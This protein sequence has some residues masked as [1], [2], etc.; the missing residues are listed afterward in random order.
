[1]Q[2]QVS[3]DAAPS[4]TAGALVVPVFAGAALNGVAA[5]VDAVL[6]GELADA[7][8]SGEITG[9]L[10]EVVLI[11][12]KDAPFKRVLAVGLGERSKMTAGNVAKYAGTAVRYLGKRGV[13]EIAIAL[14]E[15][16]DAAA[17]AS[18]VAEG[19]IAGTLDATLYRTEADKPVVTERVTILSG[20]NADQSAV[21]TGAK[22][23]RILGEAVNAARTMALTPGNDMTPTHLAQRAKDLAADA[24]LGFDV[25]DEDQ[26][27]AKHMGS[28]LGVSRGSDE[29]ATLSVMTY[30]GDPSSNETLALVG[31][32]LTFDSGGIS[33]KPPENMHE[34]K[35]DMSGGAGVIAAM[36]AIGKLRPKLNVI[37]LVPSSENLPGP[38]AMKPGDILTAMNGKTIEVLNTDAEGRLILADALAYAVELGATKIIDAA[39]LTGACVVALGHAA[40]GAMSNDDGFV[41]R[42]LR[43]VADIGE[44]Y[45]RLPLYPEYDQQIKSE[46]ADLKNTGG[47]PGGA[48]TA[49]AFLKAFVSE[50]PWIHLDVAGTAYLDSESPYLAKGPTG[51]PVRAFLNIVE[52]LAAHGF[53][54]NGVTAK[55][56]AKIT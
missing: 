55:A 19:A 27:R 37:G 9:K 40:S 35:Y 34:M 36:W 24:G 44:R 45:W 41:E 1:M 20:S 5:Q 6:G 11:H 43:V 15:G 51:T 25:L 38:R 7:L 21:E 31:K 29:P 56:T 46:I 14:P 50:T 30:K 10:N 28:L 26:M 33:L 53:S 18:F 39:T 52:D 3:S 12:A 32:G 22:R 48:E 47:R 8:G 54:T 17:A 16:I 2:V 42:F 4:V 49:G 23:G 13:R